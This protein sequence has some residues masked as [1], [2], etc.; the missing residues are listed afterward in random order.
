MPN[1]KYIVKIDKDKKRLNRIFDDLTVHREAVI[2]NYDK[3]WH[4]PMQDFGRIAKKKA[5]EDTFLETWSH[6]NQQTQHVEKKLIR[7][8]PDVEIDKIVG[9]GKTFFKFKRRKII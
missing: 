3:K 9:N 4:L 6:R 1:H 5:L 8:K 7:L 2:D